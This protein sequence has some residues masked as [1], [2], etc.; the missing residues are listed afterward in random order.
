MHHGCGAGADG[1]YLPLDLEVVVEENHG[2]KLYWFQHW[3][4]E[5]S[6]SVNLGKPTWYI[7]MYDNKAIMRWKS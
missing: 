1:R 6:K 4:Y 3:V 7:G 2:T 5:G